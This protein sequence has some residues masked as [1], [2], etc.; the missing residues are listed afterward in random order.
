M[1]EVVG[2]QEATWGGW[3]GERQEGRVECPLVVA[4]QVVGRVVA[5]GGEE[6]APVTLVRVVTTHLGVSIATTT[7][8]RHEGRQVAVVVAEDGDVVEGT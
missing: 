2:V 6:G 1:V 7:S 4:Q 3:W 5:E 8:C